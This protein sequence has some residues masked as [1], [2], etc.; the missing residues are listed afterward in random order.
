[1]RRRG[2]V[3]RAVVAGFI[4]VH[5]IATN[6]KLSMGKPSNSLESQRKSKPQLH[7]FDLR[8][9][10]ALA[11]ERYRRKL[12]QTSIQDDPPSEWFHPLVKSV[13]ATLHTRNDTEAYQHFVRFRH[14]SRFERQARS[15]NETDLCPDWS[16]NYSDPLCLDSSTTSSATTI[17]TWNSSHRLTI[18]VDVLQGGQFNHYQGIPLSQGY[19]THYVHLWVGSPIPQRQSVI[20]DTGSHFTAFP[21]TGC[22]DC[23]HQHHTDPY[24]DPSQSQTFHSLLCPDECQEQ[25]TCSTTSRRCEFTQSYTEGSSWTAYQAT[26]VLYAGGPD[27]LEA[28]NPL[29]RQ[30]SLPFMFGCLQHETGLFITQLADGIM[31]LSAHETTLPKQLY[32]QGKLEYNM[33]AMCFR[34]ELGTSKRGVTAGSMTLGGVSSTLDT[35]PMVFA[36]NTQPFG[37]FTVQVQNIYIAKNGGTQF[38]LDHTASDD[39]LQSIVKVP[40]DISQVN[41]GKGVIVDSGTTDTYLNANVM[42]AFVKVWRQVAGMD[43]THTPVFLTQ[44]QLQRL[45]TILIQCQAAAP[46]RSTSTSHQAAAA[47]P[48]LADGPIVMGQVGRLDWEHRS[49]VLLAIPAEHYMEYSPALKLY[50]S[51]LYFTETRGGVLGANAMLGKNVLF[52]WQHG[53]IGFSQSSCE[54]DLID[55]K[56]E[57]VNF[58]SE[59]YRQGNCVLGEPILTT[60]C[61]ESLDTSVCFA[62]DQPDN[63]QVLGTETWTRIVESP[64]ADQTSCQTLAKELTVSPKQPGEEESVVK[65]TLKG[66]CTEYRPCQVPCLEI[67]KAT[68]KSQPKKKQSQTRSQSQSNTQVGKSVENKSENGCG[69]TFWSACDFDC[70]QSRLV[71]KLSPKGICVETSRKSR[72]CHIDACGRT[73]PCV[74]P[75]LVHAILV[76]ETRK[77]DHE[78]TLKA[79][80]HFQKEFT[81]VSHL[82]EFSSIAA[83]RPLFQEGDVDVLVVRPWRENSEDDPDKVEMTD[84]APKGSKGIQLILQVSIA[85]PKVHKISSRTSERKLRSKEDWFEKGRQ[86]VTLVRQYFSLSK[87]A[88]DPHATVRRALMSVEKPRELLQEV[89]VLWQNLTQPFRKP[90]QAFTCN[91]SDLYPLAKDAVELA[92]GILEHPKFGKRLIENMPPYRKAR[93]VSSWTIGTQVYDDKINYYGHI[94]T[95]PYLFIFRVLYETSIVFFFLSLCSCLIQCFQTYRHW[96]GALRRKC[97]GKPPRYHPLDTRSD[98]P[99][100][101]FAPT[102]FSPNSSNNSNTHALGAREM[103]NELELAYINS[104]HRS[105]HTSP[106][107]RHLSVTPSNSPFDSP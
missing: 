79:L 26:D 32:N 13:Y 30:Y 99:D 85:N 69:E 106:T 33:F 8:P 100:N 11:E 90:K 49:D 7:R 70:E 104:G 89:G 94:A 17:P 58:A 71:S 24:F 23:G 51:R 1:M 73:D 20:V 31:G 15:K 38:L 59:I 41:S 76:L 50:T 97:C 86:L 87:P 25:A 77:E 18:D 103:T 22:H 4:F 37:W 34:K 72:E 36:R 61:E 64:G 88:P 66:L 83:R 55:P 28:A 102:T 95:T 16:G 2:L 98:E 42:P 52:D 107:K 48:P 78:W 96:C 105:N 21:C 10:G 35:T 101:E 12:Q 75:F 5:A 91:P 3:A 46:L 67:L 53:R 39:F 63:V 45:P 47:T 43:Y 9:T 27:V 60:P 14:L 29:D 84:E 92:N 93:V 44:S 40:I 65:C 80:E 57:Q 68:K 81:R 82:P 62:S 6:E 19:G 56:E 74:V 54:Y